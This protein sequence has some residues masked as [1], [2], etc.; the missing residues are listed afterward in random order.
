MLDSF[1]FYLNFFFENL[2]SNFFLFFILYFFSLI[3][4]FS[5]SLPGGPIF[6][7]ASGFFFGIYLGF[8]INIISMIIGSYIFI[9]ILKNL[10]NRLFNSFYAKFSKKINNLLKHNSYE[11][12]ILMRLITGTPLFVQNL[13]FSFIN[14]SKTKFL[15][16]SFLGFSPIIILLTYFGSKLYEIYEIK[17]FKMSDVISREFVFFSILLITLIII[18]I[19]Y[20]NK[21]KL[22]KNSEISKYKFY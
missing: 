13:L 1:Y 18:R 12:L 3:I 8:L 7:I 11:Y 14:I 21:K 16:T 22:N 9:F 20:K 19:V 4:F 2:E 17:D 15:I 10:F 5:F 6:L